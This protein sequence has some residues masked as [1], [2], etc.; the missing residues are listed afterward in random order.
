VYFFFEKLCWER[1]AAPLLVDGFD[2]FL[3][4]FREFHPYCVVTRALVV[5]CKLLVFVERETHPRKH[6]AQLDACLDF[7]SNLACGVWK[8]KHKL[9]SLS[10]LV[11]VVAAAA[12]S[13]EKVTMTQLVAH[14]GP[15]ERHITQV[16]N[17]ALVEV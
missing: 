2:L 3:V 13:L 6:R 5:A 12:V 14:V 4:V 15:V 8:R 11:L 16:A 7:F 9:V 1:D 17:V 10:S